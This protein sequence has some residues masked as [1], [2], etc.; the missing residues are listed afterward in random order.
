V[1]AW[2][3]SLALGGIILNI[4]YHLINRLPIKELLP[5]SSRLLLVSCVVGAIFSYIVFAVSYSLN[6]PILSSSA[7]ILC[8]AMTIAIPVWIHP[9][10]KEIVGW[11][12]KL[13]INEV[14]IQ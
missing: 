14:F 11:I 1:G 7:V 6:K 3:L 8:F 13:K 5:T 9:L 10:R 4:A 12:T 2:S